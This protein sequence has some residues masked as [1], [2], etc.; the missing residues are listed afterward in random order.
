MYKEDF[1]KEKMEK[2]LKQKTIESLSLQVQTLQDELR[3]AS[4]RQVKI[5]SAN[6]GFIVWK[7]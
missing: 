4:R 6:S 7:L 3:K 2:D 1:L 5:F